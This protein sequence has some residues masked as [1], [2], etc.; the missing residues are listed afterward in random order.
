MVDKRKALYV[1]PEDIMSNEYLM[2]LKSLLNASGFDVKGIS[3]LRNA[4]NKKQSTVLFS[5]I[6]DRVCR[7]HWKFSTQRFREA[8]LFL[9]NAKLAGAKVVW[10]KHNY[11]PHDYNEVPLIS[12]LYYRVMLFLIKQFSEVKLVHSSRFADNNQKYDYI[13]HPLYR[14]T[15]TCNQLRKDIPFLIFGKL[16]KYKQIDRVLEHWPKDTPLLIAGKPES[17][18]YRKKNKRN[19]S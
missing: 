12:R 9:L 13:P 2:N 16:M 19:Y 14:V 10:I 6:E 11:K 5:W 15:N 17:L 3:E 1:Y 4:K 7:R 8:L 18:D